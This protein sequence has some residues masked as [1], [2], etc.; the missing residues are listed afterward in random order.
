MKLFEEI[1]TTFAY[2]AHISS[3]TFS[4]IVQNIINLLLI[5]ASIGIMTTVN[6]RF[7]CPLTQLAIA[8]HV[9]GSD[10]I[11]FKRNVLLRLKQESV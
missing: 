2:W 4:L 7:K 9:F 8:E 1:R 10:E 5:W 11:A 3:L 6:D